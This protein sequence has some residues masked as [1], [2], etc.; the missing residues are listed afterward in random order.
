MAE[1]DLIYAELTRQIIGAALE[2]HNHLGGGFLES[3]YEIALEHEFSEQGIQYVR[4]K[5]PDVFYKKWMVKQFICDY[6]VEDK[7]I[8]ELKAIK[9][10]T[11]VEKAQMINYLKAARLKVGLLINFGS[12]SLEYKRFVN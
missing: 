3:V 2:I 12:L 5:P 4:Q 9:A 10:L 7:V 1:K 11:E 8:V 6:L